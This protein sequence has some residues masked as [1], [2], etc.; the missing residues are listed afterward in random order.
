MSYKI[1]KT[2][3]ELL[4]DLVDGQID[5]TSTDITLVGR[6]YKGFGEL[7]N[8]NFI[9]LL[10]NF[11][12]TSA[13]TSPLIGQLWY[14]TA[15]ERLKIYTGETFRSASGAVIGQT[16]PNLV[17][18][19]LW[20][21]SLNNK[22]YFFDGAD[23]VL[24]G[25][26]YSE[27]QGRTSVEAATILDNTGQDQTVLYMYIAGQ[28]TG[29]YSRVQFR[30]ATNITG[31]PVDPADTNVPKR[32][33]IKQGFNPVSSDFIWQGAAQSTQSLISDS[34]EV[35][36]EANFMKTDRDTSTT[37]SLSIRDRDGLGLN[38][39]V[40]DTTYASFK[41]A[42]NTLITQL[43]LQQ[44]NKD[45]SLRV[46]RGNTFDDALF[47]DT[48]LQRMGIYTNTPTVGFDV[49]TDAKITGDVTVTG[50]LTVTGD[51]VFVNSQTL[52]VEDKNIELSITD[53]L[54]AGDDT[55]ADGGGIILKSTDSDKS[56]LWLDDTNNWTI[57]Q[58]LDLTSTHAYKINNRTLLSANRLHD[59]ILYAEG[60]ISLGT[61]TSLSVEGNISITS[62]GSITSTSSISLES[63]GA[64]S[65][66]DVLIQ[67]VATPISARVAALD[68]LIEDDNDSVAT[69]EYVDQEIKAEPVVLTLDTT[70]LSDPQ[71]LFSNNGPYN[72]VKDI[73]D[74]LYPASEKQE[75]TVARIHCT[76]YTAT[77]VTNIE[78][79]KLVDDPLNPGGPQ[80]SA[81]RI[82]YI[83]VDDSTDGDGR[84]SVVED[85][86]FL[87]VSATAGL[88]PARASMEF[89]VTSGIWV[90]QRTTVL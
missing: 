49:N 11:A 53:G 63:T 41:V 70:G 44:T 33:L 14:D 27:S 22:L 23:I 62:G 29:I 81:A 16:Q 59:D 42:K 17:A 75:E 10:E 74:F 58:D 15:E 87:P 24:V 83:E 72:D 54:A 37:G 45:F 69:K 51:S 3:G 65:V 25:P 76:S 67:G 36:T 40:N 64:I 12:K 71:P 88:S 28:L 31:F 57:N 35:F 52:Q 46:K 34:G 50:N 2:N 86:E 73:L 56:I 79:D 32:Q 4:V 48:S 13:P 84:V 7:V 78:V 90:W 80:I 85:I 60:V 21:D 82:S 68:L 66:N 20:I 89:K 38:I 77:E 61:L 39:G 1:N 9:K 55:V 47:I 26:Q 19:D 18:G 43:E 6:N 8:E 5:Q 30:P